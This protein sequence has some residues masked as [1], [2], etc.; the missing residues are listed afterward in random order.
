MILWEFLVQYLCT[1]KGDNGKETVFSWKR[2]K[3]KDFMVA[4]HFAGIESHFIES[5]GWFFGKFIFE[6]YFWRE[7]ANKLLG[8]EV[9]CSFCIAWKRSLLSS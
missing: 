4:G 8:R 7:T 1:K 2:I 3:M 6:K 5:P 9:F